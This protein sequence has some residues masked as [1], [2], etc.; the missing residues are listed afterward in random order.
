MTVSKLWDWVSYLLYTL[1]CYKVYPTAADSLQ[2][3]A[4]FS[5][6]KSFGSA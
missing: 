6:L 2:T 3:S 4:Q 1:A 5:L